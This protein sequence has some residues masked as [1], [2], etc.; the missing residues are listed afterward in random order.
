MSLMQWLAVGGIL[1][2]LV[3]LLVLAWAYASGRLKAGSD[4]PGV[5][6]RWLPHSLRM[7]PLGHGIYQAHDERRAQREEREDKA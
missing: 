7:K 3:V 2:F 5:R 1:L 4:E 6:S